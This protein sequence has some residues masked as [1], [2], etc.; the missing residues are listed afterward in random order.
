MVIGSWM[1]VKNIFLEP[2]MRGKACVVELNIEALRFSNRAKPKDTLQVLYQLK[3]HYW[4]HV[5]LRSCIL[6]V[7]VACIDLHW[8]Y[9]VLWMPQDNLY[10]GYKTAP[11]LWV[12]VKTLKCSDLLLTA[13]A[14]SRCWYFSAS[15]ILS[16][17]WKTRAD[18]SLWCKELLHGVE[19][20]ALLNEDFDALLI[21]TEKWPA[22]THTNEQTLVEMMSTCFIL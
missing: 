17:Q 7:A 2:F 15:S 16:L 20:I 5:Y 9:S 10:Q 11:A 14:C 1:V 6:G 22:P 8:G 4:S 13:M 12:H 21:A 18:H 3:C 19:I